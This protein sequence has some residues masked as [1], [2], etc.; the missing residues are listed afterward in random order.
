VVPD[1]AIGRIL[2]ESWNATAETRSMKTR[3]TW[4]LLTSVSA[5]TLER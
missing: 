3:S 4:P 1:A 5:P 2:P